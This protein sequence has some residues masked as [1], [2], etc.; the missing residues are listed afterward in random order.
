MKRVGEALNY[1]CHP[2][3]PYTPKQY[4]ETIVP[5]SDDVNLEGSPEEN[6]N[7]C[8]KKLE[9]RSSPFPTTTISTIPVT[10]KTITYGAASGNLLFILMIYNFQNF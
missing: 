1:T 8:E 6:K 10:T 2:C 7:L 9:N 4:D 3:T 5:S